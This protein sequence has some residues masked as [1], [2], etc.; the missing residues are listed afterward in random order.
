MLYSAI[1]CLATETFCDSLDYCS[2]ARLPI[3]PSHILILHD[4][5]CCPR[6]SS[7][8]RCC[9]GSKRAKATPRSRALFSPSTLPARA[10]P[11][12]K[13]CPCRPAVKQSSP[14]C[15]LHP[16]GSRRYRQYSNRCDMGTRHSGRC[17]SAVQATTVCVS[18]SCTGEKNQRIIVERISGS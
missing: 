18:R 2:P 12:H 4:F 1:S 6:S 5:A 7:L 17:P 16:L 15:I 3:L 9:C 13:K 8:Q 14:S 10:Y 11:S